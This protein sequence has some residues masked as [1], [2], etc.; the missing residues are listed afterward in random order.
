MT[1]NRNSTKIQRIYASFGLHGAGVQP[2]QPENS[3]SWNCL[4]EIEG[5]ELMAQLFVDVI[6]KNTNGTGKVT[7]S[8]IPAR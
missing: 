8:G 1:P 5:Q 3:D 6:I 4:K 2:R 7:A